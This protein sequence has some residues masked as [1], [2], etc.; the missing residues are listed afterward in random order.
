MF[1]KEVVKQIEVSDI[2]RIAEKM[3]GTEDE[4]NLTIGEPDL[5]VPQVIK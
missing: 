2:R 3:N 4:I 5:E 1:I